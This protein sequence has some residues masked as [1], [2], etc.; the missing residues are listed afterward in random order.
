M[1]LWSVCVA[2][3]QWVQAH[4]SLTLSCCGTLVLVLS[5]GQ[6]VRWMASR[7]RGERR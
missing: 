4:Q 5:M 2:I 1:P 7:Q 3:G 6:V